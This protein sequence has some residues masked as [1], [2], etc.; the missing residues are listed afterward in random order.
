MNCL[1]CQKDLTDPIRHDDSVDGD[2]SVVFADYHCDACKANFV[3]LE[4]IGQ[5]TE[6]N[7]KYKNY[8]LEF[9]LTDETFWVDS[10]E[11]IGSDPYA[12]W[13]TKTIF[14]LNFLP[15]LTPQNVAEK[16]PTYITFS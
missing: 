4:S 6:Y 8:T 16:L 15:A 11:L 13:E 3:M 10:I 2:Y 1:F 7:F 12:R 9:S 5:L 14:K